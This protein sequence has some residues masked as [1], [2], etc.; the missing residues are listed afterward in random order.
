M[1]GD[2]NA[3]IAIDVSTSSGGCAHPWG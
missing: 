2:R 1:F 3:A